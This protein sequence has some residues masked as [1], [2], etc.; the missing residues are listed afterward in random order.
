VVIE[1][2]YQKNNMS[3]ENFKPEPIK[4]KAENPPLREKLVAF[5]DSVFDSSVDAADR[6]GTLRNRLGYFLTPSEDNK[7]D[8]QEIESWEEK[9]EACSS[10]DNKEQFASECFKALEPLLDW[11]S[12]NP[13][14]FEA[15]LRKNALMVNNFTPLNEVMTYHRSSDS[16][17]IHVAT[18]E[19]LSIKEKLAMMKDGFT[20]LA[21][22]IKS[23]ETIQAV[24]A[25]SWI[26]AAK[27]GILENWGFKIKG[28]IS[29]ED[30]ERDFK[31]ES[32]PVSWAVANRDDFLAA[33]SRNLNR[34]IK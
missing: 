26:V 28:E 7:F 22:I 8:E 11:Y 16:I 13:R 27:P 23:D 14:E 18:S 4:R 29:P 21:D 2:I 34:E 1:N 5:I 32:R 20:K 10:I 25:I 17:F 6:L 33:V 19:T 31:S 3:F 9:L 24:S 12:Q 30:K 15:V